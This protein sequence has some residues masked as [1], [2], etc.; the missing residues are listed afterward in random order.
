MV[1]LKE[2][3]NKDVMARV[4]SNELAGLVIWPTGQ[5]TR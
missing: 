1:Y 4:S 5:G 3:H 2:A